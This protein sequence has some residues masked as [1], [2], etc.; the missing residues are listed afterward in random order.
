MSERLKVLTYNCW[1]ALTAQNLVQF[2]ELEPKGRKAERYRIQIENLKRINADVVFLQE[3]SPIAGRARDFEA[4]GYDVCTQVD[5]SGL[6]AFGFGF[7]MNLSTGLVI[8]AKPEMNMKKLFGQKLSGNP[9]FTGVDFS[10]QLTENRYA[11][12]ASSDHADFGRTLFVCTHL[13]HGT[14]NTELIESMLKRA[15]GSGLLNAEE[16]EI[17]RSEIR[18]ADLRRKNE[19]DILFSAVH[20]FEKNFDQV[21]LAGD[22]NSS[23][24][25]KAYTQVLFES[26]T[27]TYR[28]AH[29]DSTDPAYHGYTWDI[30]EDFEN[31]DYGHQFELPMNSFGREDVRELFNEYNDRKRRIDFIFLKNLEGRL[32]VLGSELLKFDAHGTLVMGSDHLAVMSQIGFAK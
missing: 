22:F 20:I 6:K 12:F 2:R 16:Y 13:H 14:E 17:S 11:V 24:S 5:Q 29:V 10:F 23:E 1:H 4:L 19:L 25:S 8:L 30:S 28:S 27:D 32:K 21:I 15:L 3:V 18:A 31:I 7:P 9:G 26:Y